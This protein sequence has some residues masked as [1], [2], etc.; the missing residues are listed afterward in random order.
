[1]RYMI[2]WNDYHLMYGTYDTTVS[3]GKPT[4]ICSRLQVIRQ[5]NESW[6]CELGREHVIWVIVLDA[7][8]IMSPSEDANMNASRG[9]I[10]GPTME[11]EVYTFLKLGLRIN[12]VGS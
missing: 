12:Q 10:T 11:A 5:C 7:P 6:C 3:K 9:I 1:M 2:P 4:L 8:V